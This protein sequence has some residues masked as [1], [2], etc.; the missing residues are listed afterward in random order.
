MFALT[1]R[2]GTGG[3]GIPGRGRDLGESIG[4]C[5][6]GVRF[7]SS[8]LRLLAGLYARNRRSIPWSFRRSLGPQALENDLVGPARRAPRHV[9]AAHR[10][11]QQR[12]PE[13][14]ARDQRRRP[15]A[16]PSPIGE[17]CGRLRGACSRSQASASARRQ[18]TIPFRIARSGVRP[19]C[20]A[21]GPGAISRSA[22]IR[23]GSNDMIAARAGI[24]RQAR[25]AA[26]LASRRSPSKRL[27]SSSSSGDAP[28]DEI[29]QLAER[30][31]AVAVLPLNGTA[32]MSAALMSA[33]RAAAIG[34]AAE[35]IVVM[36]HGLAVGADLQVGL[37]AV[38]AGNGGAQRPRPCSRS[39]RRGVMQAA[40]RDRP[41]GEPSRRPGRR[42]GMFTADSRTG[43]RLRPRH[44]AG[45]AATPTVVRAWRPL[46]PNAS[47]IRSEAPF[48]TFGPSV[49]PG[50][51]LMKPPS[52]TT[53]VTLSR[54]PSAALSLGQQIDRAGARRLLSVLDRD[55]A[56]EL[57][58]GD[59]LAVGAE[60]KLAGDHQQIAGAHERHI[61]GDRRWPGV[62]SDP[63]SA[64]FFSTVPA[65][66]FLRCV[67][68]A[69]L[70]ADSWPIG[71]LC[72]SCVGHGCRN[73]LRP[74]SCP[75]LA[76]SAVS[77]RMLPWRRGLNP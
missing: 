75:D 13:Q 45:S 37:D 68:S 21:S 11:G 72:A 12:Q 10:P 26:R 40:M 46:S 73:P 25:S 18:A 35:R 39:R 5:G 63:E 44:R 65:I 47:T 53:R 2:P 32:L 9:F 52:R 67:T 70:G 71:M 30:Q 33:R 1:V 34:Q 22:S 38:A 6:C 55:A 51:E 69:S 76:S 77:R 14:P 42:A 24:A 61:V 56:A 31:D 41:R 48:I 49:K 64:S 23:S 28:G 4:R 62:G 57:A 29:A 59:Q 60:A 15:P 58:L 50:A 36:H 74:L 16:G 66:D 3:A 7:R 19:R 43:L 54:S 20:R 27:L 8:G 17:K